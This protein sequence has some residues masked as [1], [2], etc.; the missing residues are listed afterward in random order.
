MGSW[1]DGRITPFPPCSAWLDPFVDFVT[2]MGEHG[3][4]RDSVYFPF[5]RQLTYAGSTP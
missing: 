5:R 2:V 4:D 1:V 3:G